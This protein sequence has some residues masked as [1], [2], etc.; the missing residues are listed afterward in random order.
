MDRPA[1]KKGMD[2]P[3]SELGTDKPAS[4]LGADKPA[5]EGTNRPA[6]EAARAWAGEH[7]YDLLSRAASK[8]FVAR[9][10]AGGA[11][12]SEKLAFFSDSDTFRD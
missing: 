3:A 2:R 10:A 4:D 5:S 8:V 12:P 9:G 11:T 1:S 6:S 7:G